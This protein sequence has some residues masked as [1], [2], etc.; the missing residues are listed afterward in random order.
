MKIQYLTRIALS[1]SLI[2]LIERA[3]PTNAQQSKHTTFLD[4]CQNQSTIASDPRHTVQKLLEKV[5]TTNCQQGNKSLL[6]L[7][8]LDLS[9]NEIRNIEPLGNLTNLK[10]LFLKSNQITNLQ[11]LAK[12]KNLNLLILDKNE[13]DNIEPLANLTNLFGLGLSNNKIT[14]VKPLSKLTKLQTLSLRYNQLTT[15]HS[16][17]NL[18]HLESISLEGNRFGN[19]K[20]CPLQKP[21][22][23]CIF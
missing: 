9:G 6:A 4:W 19:I 5:N 23:G 16:L 13:I 2:C 3:I 7:T 17:R 22:L 14:N 8:S 11:A 10:T 12:L 20:I 1:I 15:V 21:N 18:P